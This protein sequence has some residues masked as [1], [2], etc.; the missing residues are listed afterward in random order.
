MFRIFPEYADKPVYCHSWLLSPL[1]KDMLPPTS[2]ILRFQEMF[3][4]APDE[5][6]SNDVLLWVFKNPKLPKEDLPEDS[7]LQRKLKRFLL[8][9]NQFLAG[10]G[11]LRMPV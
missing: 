3:D 10:K 2:N 7:S 4:I 6:P 5:K 8:A 9:G 11:Y 1:L